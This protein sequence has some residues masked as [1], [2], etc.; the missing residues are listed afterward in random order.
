MEKKANIWDLIE[1][2]VIIYAVYSLLVMVLPVQTWIGTALSTVLSILVMLYVFGLVS[3][4]VAKEKSDITPAKAGA[5]A[6]V[7]I[8]LISAVIGIISYYAYPEKIAQAIQAAVKQG[9]DAQTVQ[10]MV[11]IGVY[12]NIIIDPIIFALIGAFLSWLGFFVFKKRFAGKRR[13]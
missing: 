3:Y 7:A 5:Y 4:K 8:G 2:S 12:I 10:T 11:Q 1:S 13:K 6:G 9:V